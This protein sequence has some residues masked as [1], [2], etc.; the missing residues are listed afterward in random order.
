MAGDPCR[1]LLLSRLLP[2]YWLPLTT[3]SPS[4][5]PLPP[6]S[7]LAG[8]RREGGGGEEEEE[9]VL[10]STSEGERAALLAAS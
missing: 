9:P 8:G 4:S 7:L 5:S 10:H 2:S 1:R 3:R 6:F